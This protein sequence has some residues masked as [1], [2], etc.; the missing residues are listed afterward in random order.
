MS[1]PTSPMKQA[2]TEWRQT[3]A[4]SGGTDASPKVAKIEKMVLRT[5]WKS[6]ARDCRG[7]NLQ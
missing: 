1:K 4:F 6:T 7:Y 5:E 3:L 2:Q